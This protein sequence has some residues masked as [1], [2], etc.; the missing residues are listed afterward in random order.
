MFLNGVYFIHESH[1]YIHDSCFKFW[2]DKSQHS[3]HIFLMLALSLQIVFFGFAMPR[4][5]FFFFFLGLHLLYMEVP[6]LRVE[7]EL[8][9]LANT[10]ATAMPDPSHVCDLHHGSQHHWILN[11]LSKARD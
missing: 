2:S 11:P 9:L 7:R 4:N 10:T 6:R 5:F 1:H 8:Q 3:C